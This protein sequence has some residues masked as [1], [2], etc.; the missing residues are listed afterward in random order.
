MWW[1]WLNPSFSTGTVL[2]FLSFFLL[3]APYTSVVSCKLHLQLM[4]NSK[5]KLEVIPTEL[6]FLVVRHRGNVV[7][8]HLKEFKCWWWTFWPH[9][10]P[11]STNI[12][13]CKALAQF[14]V[15]FLKWGHTNNSW[16]FNVLQPM[17]LE[18]CFVRYLVLFIFQK[19]NKKKLC[20]IQQHDSFTS[21]IHFM[22]FSIH[23]I[24]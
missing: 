18:V 16:I 17:L 13:Y 1:R 20:C 4:C 7:K 2:L 23:F 6:H 9:A 24:M 10:S 22:N 21:M 8:W 19:K 5:Y 15:W 11:L 3:Y 14:E 12:H